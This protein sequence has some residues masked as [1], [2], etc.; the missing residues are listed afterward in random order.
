MTPRLICRQQLARE[1]CNKNG[2]LFLLEWEWGFSLKIKNLIVGK[3]QYY[4]EEIMAKMNTKYVG[5]HISSGGFI[6]YTDESPGHLYVL[7]IKNKKGEWW[8]PK[9]HIEKNEDQIAAA[10]REIEEE[11]GLKKEQ[12]KYIGLCHLYKFSFTDD[13]GQP[14]TKEI[15][16]NVFEA[17]GIHNLV[18]EQNDT[19]DIRDVK[20]FVYEEGLEAIMS[21]SRNELVRAKEMYEG[22]VENSR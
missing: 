22:F 6:F 17:T 13:N 10:F 4:N 3:S 5:H 2:R 16:M 19:T 7:L 1:F 14:N 18:A 12:L 8:I 20:W 15:Y 21:F 9:G 11:V